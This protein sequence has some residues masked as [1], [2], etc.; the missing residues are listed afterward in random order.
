MPRFSV[1]VLYG[2]LKQKATTFLNIFHN[3]TQLLL[4][5]IAPAVTLLL[6][7]RKFH[8]STTRALYVVLTETAA[9]SSRPRRRTGSDVLTDGCFG[10]RHKLGREGSG[11]CGSG[12]RQ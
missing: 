9:Q 10:K 6:T 3:F 12:P 4:H 2:P 5:I 7:F 11:P 8:E 1:M